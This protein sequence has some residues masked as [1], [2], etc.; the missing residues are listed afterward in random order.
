SGAETSIGNARELLDEMAERVREHLRQ[1]DGLVLSAEPDAA[2][3]DDPG[4]GEAQ[5]RLI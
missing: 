1:I 2:S 4:A 5:E 3:A